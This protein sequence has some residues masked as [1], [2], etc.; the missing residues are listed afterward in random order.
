[1]A[2]AP[3]LG[4]RRRPSVTGRWAVDGGGWRAGPGKKAGNPR[5]TGPDTGGWRVDE[6]FGRFNL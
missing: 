5:G 2:S 6:A 3:T 1:M 4:R